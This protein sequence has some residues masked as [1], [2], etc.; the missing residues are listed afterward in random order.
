MQVIV[1]KNGFKIGDNY[2]AKLSLVAGAANAHITYNFCNGT[3]SISRGGNNMSQAQMEVF[4]M[5]AQY[6]ESVAITGNEMEVG[7]PLTAAAWEIIPL[8]MLTSVSGT[9]RN[10]ISHDTDTK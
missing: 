6:A 1:T 9:R 10:N 5:T 4:R 3:Y 7:G 2:A 8:N